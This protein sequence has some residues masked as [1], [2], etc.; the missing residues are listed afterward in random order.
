MQTLLPLPG[1]HL[2]SLHRLICTDSVGTT[3]FWQNMEIN[4]KSLQPANA[5]LKIPCV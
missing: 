3:P 1:I 5:G 4:V 2:P